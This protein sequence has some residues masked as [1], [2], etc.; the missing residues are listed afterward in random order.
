MFY[1]HK[2]GKYL[3]VDTKYDPRR[4]AMSNALHL[5]TGNP[6]KLSGSEKILLDASKKMHFFL[7]RF[8]VTYDYMQQSPH[9]NLTGPQP[10]TK[11]PAFDGS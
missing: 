11:F 4:L 1:D 6:L 7:F 10:V 2:V 8:R 3:P 5:Y 9:E